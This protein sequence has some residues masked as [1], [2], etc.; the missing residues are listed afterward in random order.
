[1]INE[2]VILVDPQGKEL[3]EKEKMQ[4]HRDGD[5]HLAF[6]VLIYRQNAGQRE[7]L[8]QQRALGKYHSGGLWTNSCCS[9]P[10]K[11][12]TMEQAGIRRLQ[13]EMGVVG[14]NQ[15]DDIASFLY[16]AELDNHL[17]EHELD[18][19]L[20]HQVS[21]LVI[22]PNPEEVMSY[23]W[24]PSGD[25]MQS[26]EQSPELFTAWFPQVLSETEAHR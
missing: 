12:E 3:G 17:V 21:E 20:V 24:W 18:H 5:L 19:I 22:D 2:Q 9:H 13:E 23:R 6:S 15:L 8:M 26:V 10:R 25:L 4:A 11:G 16:R 7:Y 14:I 1:M